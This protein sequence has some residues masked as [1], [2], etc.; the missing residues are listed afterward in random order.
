MLEEKREERVALRPAEHLELLRNRERS[1][2]TARV[3]V[4]QCERL[5][6]RR[7]LDEMDTLQKKNSTVRYGKNGLWHMGET[8]RVREKPEKK[9]R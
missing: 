6:E 4:T 7:R 9:S 3:E 1:E 8:G 5:R 2:P